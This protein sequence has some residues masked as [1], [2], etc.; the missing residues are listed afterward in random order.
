MFGLPG[1]P[2]G[3]RLA[4]WI[5][6]GTTPEVFIYY[7]GHS[8]P[9]KSGMVYIVPSDCAPDAVETGGYSIGVLYDNVVALP[10]SKATVVID[11]CF[12]G[13]TQEGMIVSGASPIMMSKMPESHLRDESKLTILA[14]ARRTQFSY[15]TS[16]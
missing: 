7:V 14:A 6:S 15:V 5:R 3:R 16:R 12:S 13:Q 4:S 1:Q 9:S 2:E 10:I 11:A 8:A